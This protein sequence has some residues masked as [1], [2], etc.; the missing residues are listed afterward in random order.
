MIVCNAFILSIPVVPEICCKTVINP[1]QN[2]EI[3]LVAGLGEAEAD[4]IRLLEC[5]CN[6]HDGV[7]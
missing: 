4:V 6:I 5:F 2:G 3:V 7:C 1:F